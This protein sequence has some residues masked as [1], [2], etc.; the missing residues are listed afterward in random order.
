MD[1]EKERLYISVALMNWET[2]FIWFLTKQYF[3][4]WLGQARDLTLLLY[5]PR[6]VGYLFLTSL[7][8]HKVVPPSYK[9]VIM[10]LTIDIYNII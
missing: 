9:W 8:I 5:I 1:S 7:S 2:G 10:S 3:M 4:E 6:I